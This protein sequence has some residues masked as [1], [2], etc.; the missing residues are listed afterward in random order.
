[1][2]DQRLPGEVGWDGGSVQCSQ[3]VA[4]WHSQEQRL[5]MQEP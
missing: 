4:G 2:K 3:A 1:M 5:P